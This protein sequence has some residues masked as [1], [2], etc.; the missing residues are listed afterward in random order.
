MSRY[1]I[2]PEYIL[3][4]NSVIKK[5]DIKPHFQEDEG[6][7]LEKAIRAL[8]NNKEIPDFNLRKKK[9]LR[10]FNEYLA[11]KYDMEPEY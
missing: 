11:E 2:V 1:G 8:K 3:R 7:S 9:S 10:I 6:P 4:S 5:K